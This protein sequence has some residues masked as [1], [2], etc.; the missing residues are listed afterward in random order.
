VRSTLGEEDKEMGLVFVGPIGNETKTV[1]AAHA[2]IL[3]PHLLTAS[4]SSACARAGS[5]AYC[6]S[7]PSRTRRP[8]DLVD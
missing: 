4:D 1:F 7:G 5:S 8:G 3:L 2:A 6:C